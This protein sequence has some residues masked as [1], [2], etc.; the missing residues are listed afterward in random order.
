[1]GLF[2]GSILGGLFGSMGSYGGG[3]LSGGSTFTSGP[4][5]R[6]PLDLG[7]Y[8]DSDT[9][10]GEACQIIDDA[11]KEFFELCT[12]GFAEMVIKGNKDYKTSFKIREEADSKIGEAM[13][14]YGERCCAF[15]QYLKELND[16]INRLYEDKAKLAQ[17][18]GKRIKTLPVI[19]AYERT[20]DAPKYSYTS[21]TIDRICTCMGLREGFDIKNRKDSAREYLE[22]ARDYEVEVLG[23]ISKINRAQVFLDT[24]RAELEEERMIVDALNDSLSL[25]RELKYLE[26]GSRLNIL[27]SEFVLDDG[28]KKNHRYLE[29]IYQLKSIS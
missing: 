10:L 22:D 16:F 2:G 18:L 25:E 12:E 26:I 13:C 7:D 23:Q 14:R 15:N 4:I 8:R 6:D 11:K 20:M 9:L 5:V 24:V 21:S 17:R 28:G 1:M 19:P 27:L 29:A 3:F